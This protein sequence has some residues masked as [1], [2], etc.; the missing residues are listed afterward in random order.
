[1]AI[2]DDNKVRMGRLGALPLY[3]R[4]LQSDNIDEQNLGTAGLWILAFKDENKLL[5][6]TEPGCLDGKAH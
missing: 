5:L 6:K 2:N 3:I 1:M 4:L